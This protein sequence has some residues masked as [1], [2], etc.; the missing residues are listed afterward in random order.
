VSI[1]KVN[2]KNG[3][4]KVEHTASKTPAPAQP[5]IAA[6]QPAVDI[7]SGKDRRN[8][9]RR[10][11]EIPVA[12]ERRQMERRTKVSRRRQIDPTTCE[13]DYSPEEIEFM[14]ALDAY[15]R[16][17]GRMFPTCSEV[18]EVF[19]GLGYEKRP[20]AAP[21]AIVPENTVP[22]EAIVVTTT[23]ENAV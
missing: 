11:K 3:K 8:G 21:L 22:I 12:A 4:A 17:S 1:K 14:A 20:A 10:Q 9:D 7:R 2:G 5:D 16:R 23:A 19:K 6:A 13:R 15:K 18:L